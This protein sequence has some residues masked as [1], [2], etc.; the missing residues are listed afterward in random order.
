L[1]E[2]EYAQVPSSYF[3]SFDATLQATRVY[4]GVVFAYVG[5]MAYPDLTAEIARIL[6]R[7]E[8]SRW[9]ICMGVHH[10]LLILS[11]RTQL[12]EG[13][14]ELLVQAIVGDEGTAGGHGP[15][16]GGQIPLKGR[17]PEQLARLLQEKA[18]RV[19]QVSSEVRGERLI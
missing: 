16:A 11:V 6:L 17:E 12:P 8:R 14:A 2:I 9:I 13:K 18:L 15:S 3:R 19:L 5:Q 7:L 1:S 10:E 4:D